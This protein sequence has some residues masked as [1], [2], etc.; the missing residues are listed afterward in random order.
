M[1]LP[2]LKKEFAFTL[3]QMPGELKKEHTE[4]TTVIR[5]DLV[6]AIFLERGL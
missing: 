3:K 5:F 4:E 2:I 6:R 1:T